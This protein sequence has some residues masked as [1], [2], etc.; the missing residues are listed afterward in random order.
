MKARNKIIS[1]I[2]TILCILTLITIFPNQSY[3]VKNSAES[4]NKTTYS[5]NTQSGD[6]VYFYNENIIYKVNTKTKKTTRLLKMK[7]SCLVF[8]IN[9]YNNYIYFISMNGNNEKSQ[10]F[11]YKVKTDGTG[12][13]KLAQGFDMYI[14]NGSIYYIKT[15]GYLT[16]SHN[17]KSIGIYKMSTNGKNNKLILKQNGIYSM[18]V[19]NSNIYYKKSEHSNIYKISMTGKACGYI[20]NTKNHIIVSVTKN[21]L[22]TQYMDNYNARFMKYNFTTKKWQTIQSNAY[23][24]TANDNYAYYFDCAD[25][26][27]YVYKKNLK[28][29]KILYKVYYPYLSDLQVASNYVVCTVT[30]ST[31]DNRGHCYLLDKNGNN[32][33][34]LVKFN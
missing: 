33:K 15:S 14:N 1:I 21:N 34:D 20:S 25:D 8:D 22:Y 19:N 32:I 6:Y 5:N 31:K 17:E 29:N 28:T 9:V 3:A 7:N 2:M 27:A 16:S 26:G 12:L 30:Y 13:K 11:I 10:S 24:F 23:A 4:T 18:E